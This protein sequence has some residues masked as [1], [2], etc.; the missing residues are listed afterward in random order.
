MRSRA[1]EDHAALTTLQSSGAVDT[2]AS[3]VFFHLKNRIKLADQPAVGFCGADR[4][5]SKNAA[6][7][8]PPGQLT[9]S[10]KVGWYAAGYDDER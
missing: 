4:P 3:P 9:P 6:A 10:D 5:I 2:V 7:D 1:W 8:M